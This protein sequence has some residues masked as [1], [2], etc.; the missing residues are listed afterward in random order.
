MYIQRIRIQGDDIQSL[1]S[2]RDGR[3]LYVNPN[4]HYFNS[5]FIKVTDAGKCANRNFYKAANTILLIL[6]KNVII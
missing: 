5:N 6:N 3:V 2:I 4:I 1:Y